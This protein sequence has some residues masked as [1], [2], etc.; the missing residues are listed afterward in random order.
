M[1]TITLEEHFAT[2]EFFNGPAR[3]VKERAEKIGDRYLLVLDR[4]CDVGAKRIS[5][6][7]AAGIDMQVLSLSAPGVEQMETADAIPMA[8]ATNDYLADAISKHPTRFAGFAAVPTGAPKQA[9]EEL[10]RRVRQG[11]K[12]AVIN[13]HNKGRYLDNHFYWPL[14]E[15]AEAL[16]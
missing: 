13:G 16:N 7:D 10:E 12:G 2:P 9:A 1:R 4:L 8:S 14:L 15:C 3:F 6:M 5:E 11:F